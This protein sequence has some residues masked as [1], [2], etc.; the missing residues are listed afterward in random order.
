MYRYI[1]SADVPASVTWWVGLLAAALVVG[2]LALV[3]LGLERFGIRVGRRPA[4]VARPAYA[5]EYGR[6]ADVGSSRP[7]YQSQRQSAGVRFTYEYDR[8]FVGVENYMTSVVRETS[9]APPDLYADA[10]RW[11]R[12]AAAN[13]DDRT[14]RV[15][16]PFPEPID[17]TRRVPPPESTDATRVIRPRRGEPPY[18][19]S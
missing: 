18:R 17:R 16:D 10:Q 9:S 6:P 4:R 19:R 1:L 15:P 8:P 5:Y 14:R 3:V 12:E 2:S 7:S 13:P 11:A